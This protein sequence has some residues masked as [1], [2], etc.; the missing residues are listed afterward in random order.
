MH[1]WRRFLRFLSTSSC[2]RCQRLRN[3]F[4]PRVF[5]RVRFGQKGS[6]LRCPFGGWIYFSPKT[7]HRDV[8]IFG[9]MEFGVGSTD[10]SRRKDRSRKSVTTRFWREAVGASHILMIT[11]SWSKDMA[12][13]L[14]MILWKWGC[15]VTKMSRMSELWRRLSGNHVWPSDASTVNPSGGRGQP[16]SALQDLFAYDSKRCIWRWPNYLSIIPLY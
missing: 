8:H 10:C 4:F 5:R 11:R 14:K 1:R 15:L 9:W 2:E 13:N 6:E 7:G 12:E 3:L 16:I